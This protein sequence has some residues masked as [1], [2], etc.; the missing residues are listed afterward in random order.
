MGAQPAGA[1]RDRGGRPPR[2]AGG[3]RPRHAREGPPA[4][5][6]APSSSPR[7]L[8]RRAKVDAPARPRHRPR[9]GRRRR[10]SPAERRE[11]HDTAAAAPGAGG[12]RRVAATAVIT[13]QPARSP[14]AAAAASPGS[15]GSSP[16]SSRASASSGSACSRLLET[17]F[18]PI[19]SEVVLPLGGY[20]AERGELSP[21]GVVVAATAGSVG[22]RVGPLRPRRRPGREARDRPARR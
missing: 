16:T 21:V 14:R 11:Q 18:P 6:A 9:P 19:P 15:P 20:L 4:P 22:G 1:A 5:R 10:P 13:G 2:E 3:Q 7:T 17:V 12:P 8:P